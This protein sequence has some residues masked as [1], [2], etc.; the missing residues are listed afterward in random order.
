MTRIE[1][2]LDKV[3]EWSL[4]SLI[5]ALPFSK[6]IA[7]IAIVLALLS[8]VLRKIIL[9]EK[10]L[11]NEPIDILLYI[12]LAV[13][14]LSL[15]N[16]S[17]M[18]LSVRAF[19]TKSLKFGALFL[20]VREIITT[21]EKLNNLIIIGLLSCAVISIDGFIQYFLTH[22]DLLHNY[23]SF[24]FETL[25]PH[26]FGVPTASFPYPND[27]AA[28]IL[29]YIFPIGTFLVFGSPK[30]T[31]AIIT[32]T[33]LA[34]LGYLFFLTKVRGAWLSFMIS[35]SLLSFVRLKKI[36]VFMLIAVL[37]LALFVHK[38]LRTYVFALT[39]IND[40][41]VMWNNGWQIFKQHPII[42]NGLNTFFVNYAKVRND[43][44]KGVRGSYAHNCYLQ[45]AADIGLIGLAA[46]LAFAFSLLLKGFSSIR[47]IKDPFYYSL[48]LGLTLALSAFLL[49][50]FV[51]TNLYSL[52]LSA[53]FW[54]VSGILLS[55]IR[56][57]EAR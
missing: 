55:V 16:T 25:K 14:L 37:I 56:I 9:K 17:Y 7:E 51:D 21:R 46:F 53:L 41:A 48:I 24:N 47:R 3:A 50:S 18:G 30:T 27:F 52:N 54:S 34:C 15:F 13:S 42:G 1:V 11:R 20:A 57:A 44:S 33:L 45:M 6:S 8:V 31:A 4:Y 38:P 40:R 43:E 26:Y 22:V 39:S 35:F 5:F 10:I 49:H 32:G 2:I 28:W 36:V 23:P 29:I 19:F 12:F